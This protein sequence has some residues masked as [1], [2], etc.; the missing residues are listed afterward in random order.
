MKKYFGQGTYGDA[1]NAGLLVQAM[2]PEDHVVVYWKTVHKNLYS[3]IRKIF[4]LFR[5]ECRFVDRDI[6]EIEHL[7]VAPLVL[8]ESYV[9]IDPN[10]YFDAKMIINDFIP[11]IKPY[12]V[13][14]AHAGKPGGVNMKY[15]SIDGVNDS[16]ISGMNNVLVGTDRRF[17]GLV[18]TDIINYVGM[19]SIDEF[20]RIISCADKFTGPVGFGSFVALSFGIPCILHDFNPIAFKNRIDNNWWKKY[21]VKFYSRSYAFPPKQYP[22]LEDE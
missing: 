15:E 7:K 1:Y 21:C 16:C 9:G 20:V 14:Q 10:L 22:S 12:H 4:W 8:P 2:A 6:P 17:Y 18:A 5:I 3:D 19:T 11:K 13:I